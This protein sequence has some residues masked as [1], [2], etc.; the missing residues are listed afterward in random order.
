[1]HVITSH[2]NTDYDGLAAMVAVH[3][4]YPGSIMVWADR[5]DRNV[6]RFLSLYKDTWDVRTPSFINIDE[7]QKLTVVDTNSRRRL[8]RLS[9]AVSNKEIEIEVYDHHLLPDDRLTSK[10]YTVGAITTIFVEK[11]FQA[12]ISVN[13]VEATLFLLAIYADTNLLTSDTTT[14]KDLKMAAQLLECGADLQLV[15]QY[16]HTPLTIEQRSL[17]EDLLVKSQELTIEGIDIL[18]VSDTIDHYVDGL[19]LIVEHILNLGHY[20]TV[21]ALVE[22]EDKVFLSARSTNERMDVGDLCQNWGGGGHPGAAAAVIKDCSSLEELKREVCAKL[23]QLVKPQVTAADIMSTPVRVVSPLTTVR[24][25]KKLLLSCGHT[26]LPVVENG[27]LAGII[28]RRDLDKAE[29]HGL[30]HAPV[31]GFMTRNVITITPDTPLSEIQRILVKNDIGRLPVIHNGGLMGIVTRTDVLRQLHGTSYPHWFRKTY[32]KNNT[33]I[34]SDVN[35]TDLINSR[36]DPFIQG[37]LLLAGQTAS[38]L[39]TKVYIVGGMVRD[40]LLDRISD[41][42]DLVV[43]DKIESFLMELAKLL[44]G[45]YVFFEQFGTGR[46]TFSNQ[47]KIDCAMAR[48][49]FYAGPGALPQVQRATLAHD[50]YRRDFTINTLAID[51]NGSNFGLLIDYYGGREDLTNGIVRVLYNLSFVEDPT[52]IL[53]AVRFEQR[54]RFELEPDT[55]RFL[56]T[57]LE[58]DVLQEVSPDKLRQEF[59]LCC[60]EPNAARVLLRMDQLGILKRL[61]PLIDLTDRQI[62]ALRKCNETFQWLNYDRLPG[63]DRWLVYL[64]VLGSQ[65]PAHVRHIAERLRLPSRKTATVTAMIK[66]ADELTHSLALQSA[67]SNSFIY[68]TLAGRTVEELVYTLCLTDESVV[69]KSILKYLFKLQDIEL[70]ISGRDLIDLGVRPGPLYARLL[71]AVKTAKLDGKLRSRQDELDFLKQLLREG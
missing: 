69:F 48:S 57:A 41:D 29:H 67:P 11:L 35:L 4:L 70:E 54:Y 50:L 46:I 21:V 28:S 62:E 10:T 45:E 5:P 59:R 22:M 34:T 38:R 26:G 25:A 18:V 42:I 23:S 20:D 55:Q 14:E 49:E 71:A 65:T 64:A 15:R 39:G 19:A 2:V 68:N 8:G 30:G 27:M 12:D 37:V 17:L 6:R 63:F 53:R 32:R 36:L 43:E 9:R 44:N 52:R 16:L 3:K 13:A 40:L 47:V 7:I 58:N 56:L 51:L 33:A 66:A 61:F 31:K 24:E 1:M 60:E